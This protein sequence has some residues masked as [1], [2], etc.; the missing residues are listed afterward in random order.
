MIVLDFETHPITPT[1][2]YPM[3]V[4][5]ALK[6]NDEPGY[7]VRGPLKKLREAVMKATRF[8]EGKA[9]IVMHNGVG[10]DLGVAAKH[11]ALRFDIERIHDT[12]VLAFLDDPYRR[13]GLKALAEQILGM[14]PEEQN[15]LRGWI[16]ANVEEATPKTWGAFIYRAPPELVEPYAIGDVE[17][18]AR[19]FK[20]GVK[21]IKSSGMWEAYRREIEATP[22]LLD[23]ELRGVTVDVE[24]LMQ[25]AFKFSNRLGDVD[26]WVRKYLGARGIELDEDQKLGMA[27]EAKLKITLPRTKTDKLQTSKDVIA[28]LPDDKLRRALLYRSAL[29]QNVRTFLQP[30]AHMARDRK[31]TIATHWNLVG[32]TGAW[33]GGT[34]TGRLSSEPNFQN[35]PSVEKV[36]ELLARLGKPFSK[37]F[38]S[39]ELPRMRS[40]VVP[41][42]KDAVII[43]RDYSQQEL[44]LLAEFERSDI[45]DLYER[46]PE[47]DIHRFVGDMI[48]SVTGIEL[49]RKTIK[50]L[51]FCTIYGGGAPAVAA[52]GGM[53]IDEATRVRDLYF[54]AMPSIRDVMNETQ[55]EGRAGGIRTIGGRIYEAQEGF[56]D[57][58]PRDFAY[59]LLNYRIQGSAADQ[60]KECLRQISRSEALRAGFN[61]TVHDELAGWA[62]KGDAAKRMLRDLDDIM[63]GTTKTFKLRVPFMTEG[64]MGPNWADVKKEKGL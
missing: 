59:R 54:Q 18:T 10:F 52:Q 47:T 45:F 1:D 38:G 16:L 8:A 44:R 25:D 20:R 28:T 15:D 51:N 57:G 27:I 6:V 29:A 53:S 40:Y 17:R 32:G 49:P 14:P 64:Y 4:G 24:R 12:L 21:A 37:A 23:N 46:F 58:R 5:V 36:D 55:A 50:V 2:P 48:K 43:G 22:V 7:Y 39:W 61:L 9:P 34:K 42:H 19:L 33:G 41:P 35:I 62:P 31:G 30:W 63:I 3:P 60:M 13:L 11:L 56:V 26:D